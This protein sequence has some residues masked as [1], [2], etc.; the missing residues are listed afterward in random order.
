MKRKRAADGPRW[1]APFL[2]GVLAAGAGM[3]LV[4]ALFGRR[5]LVDPRLIR[6]AGHADGDVPPTVVIP[7]IMGSGLA[8]PDETRVWLNLRNAVGQY[9]LSLPFVLPLSDSRDDLRPGALLGTEHRLPRMF[10]FTEYFDLL[11]L[12]EAAG[13]E[14]TDFRAAAVGAFA[15]LGAI[16]SD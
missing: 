15:V 10:G 7:G 5:R 2:A 8:R 14:L 16:G 1:P 6:R 13:F 4:N 9:N 11:E 3:V 12:L